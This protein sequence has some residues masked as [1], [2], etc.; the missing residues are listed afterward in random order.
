MAGSQL[1]KFEKKALKSRIKQLKAEGLSST[2]ANRQAFAEVGSFRG[3]TALGIRRK[4]QNKQIQ[5]KG[6][7]DKSPEGAGVAQSSL[8]LS[9]ALAR[10]SAV[11]IAKKAS[12][13]AAKAAAKEAAKEA[14][15]EAGKEVAKEAGKEAGKTA[16]TSTAAGLGAGLAAKGF[17]TAIGSSGSQDTTTAVAGGAAEGAATGFTVGGAWGAA[18]GAVV[19]GGVG[20]LKAKSRRKQAAREAQAKKEEALAGIA[21]AKGDSI[22]RA[23]ANMS[24]AFGMTLR[25]NNFLGS[26]SRRTNN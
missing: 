1:D 24:T 14:G 21:K 20:A 2:E 8:D 4:D 18:V 26:F 6:F 11:V 17:Q 19:G 9:G 22:N 12:E 16:G 23:L 3:R 15:K 25:Q 7:I 13:E 5:D 10:T